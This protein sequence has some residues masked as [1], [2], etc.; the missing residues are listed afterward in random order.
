MEK[1]ILNIKGMHCASCAAN[2]EHALKDIPGVESVNVNYANEKA[3]IEHDPIAAPVHTLHMG[4]KSAGYDVVEPGAVAGMEHHKDEHAGHAKMQTDEKNIMR[5]RFWMTFV[6][7]FPVVYFVMSEMIGIPIPA[8][9]EK[10]M[11][12][13]QLVCATI[14]VGL[15]LFLWRS[16]ARSLWRR[17]PNMDALIFMGTATAYFYSLA[18]TVRAWWQGSLEVGTVYFESAI[19]ILIFILLGKYLEAITKGRTSQAMRQLISLQA[20]EATLV[21][22]G[23]EQR[24]PVAQ[25]VVGDIVRVKPGE[26]I[27]VDGIIE[28]GYSGVDEQAI[29]GESL[30][31]EKKVGDTVIGGTINGTGTFT[32][33]TSKVGEGTMLAQ[34]IRVVE[35]AM[36]SK[37][38]IQRL[39]DTVAYYFV[40]S[41]M[42]V[43]VVALA[44][45]L[46]AGYNFT[47]ALTAFVS[48]L[49]I[50]CPCALGLATP[51]AIMM[52]TGI[53][54]QRGILIKNGQALERAGK[55]T[56]VVFDKTG[57]LTKGKPEVTNIISFDP[58]LTENQVL[59]LTASVEQHSEHPLAAA[60]LAR[61]NQDKLILRAVGDFSSI[62]GKG[63]MATVD[64]HRVVIGTRLI[65]ENQKIPLPEEYQSVAANWESAGQ[66]VMFV[67]A[68][69]RLIGLI[70]LADTVRGEAGEAIRQLKQQGKK[71]VMITGDNERVGQAIASQLGIERVVAQVLPQEKSM[72][73][74]EMQAT[75]EVVAMVGDGIN[76]APA[77][78]Q[79]DLGI[80]MRS[81]TD[82]AME[83]GDIILMR[84]DPRDVITAMKL[85][86]YTVSK[87]KQNLFW[88]FIY[89]V[90]GIPI[91]AGVLYGLT[92]WLLSPAIAAAAMAFSSV[93]VVTN[94][95]LM[96]RVSLN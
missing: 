11:S 86:R 63:I 89:N 39:A 43:A 54:A 96:K 5:R 70:G 49:I 58:N 84:N 6:F 78:A 32:F 28:S 60:V 65:M 3:Y 25:L 51:T 16:G 14:V 15:S 61:S 69:G 36:G 27:P 46:L 33:R 9:L 77:L 62:P 17:R 68:D 87:I 1:T 12:V 66:T 85:S 81:G 23:L 24:I 59:L 48:V 10:F 64:G 31:I 91:A 7:G 47:F 72:R 76:D 57:T 94:S 90:I 8:A 95:L 41:V 52:G 37:A 93:S 4:V 74:K 75:G 18:V 19:F 21:R 83:T 53:A 92:G 38:P 44:G 50:A 71:T 30:P 42:I 73:V 13:I 35:Q 88:A 26:K 45:W 40:P 20:T 67:G 22:D 34:I 56:T 80:V 55:V 29:T 2:I 79:A 82:I